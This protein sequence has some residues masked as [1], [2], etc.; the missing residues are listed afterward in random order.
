VT[1][2]SN[3]PRY[4][5]MISTDDVIRTIDAYC[6]RFPHATNYVHDLRQLLASGAGCLSRSEFRGHITCSA[7]VTNVNSEV[8]MIHHRTLDRW[9]LPGGHI[10]MGDISL[11]A[12]AARELSEEVGVAFDEISAPV[13]WVEVPVHI[14][15]HTIP[16]NVAKQEPEHEHWDF[17][18]P[19]RVDRFAAAL[20]DAEV[21]DFKWC[22]EQMLPDRFVSA[23]QTMK[24]YETRFKAD[25][26]P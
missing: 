20:Q 10:E 15:R 9:L 18:Y 16:T 11:L 3:T 19:L 2:S 26:I 4:F 23:V 8:L 25:H 7:L 12:A 1:A 5:A 14:D 6:V 13:L 24:D 17:C 22:D 21:S